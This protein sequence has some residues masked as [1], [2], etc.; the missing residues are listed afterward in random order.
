MSAELPYVAFIA[1]AL[2]LVPLPWHWRARNIAT[3]SMI[4]WLFV[5][6]IIYGVD[7][8]IWHHRVSRTA[9]VW[10]DISELPAKWSGTRR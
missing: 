10:C 3:L 4:A 5:I 6:N 9:Y 2:V 1:A 8:V 7:A